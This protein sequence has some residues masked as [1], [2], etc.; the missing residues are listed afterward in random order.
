MVE[1]FLLLCNLAA[2]N[3]VRH[4]KRTAV[5]VMLISIT[6][7]LSF[8]ANAFFETSV[9][10][11][12]GTYVAGLTGHAVISEKAD[13]SFSLFGSEIPLVGQYQAIPVLSNYR[14]LKNLL[15]AKSDYLLWTPLV[16][17]ATRFQIGDMLSYQP[18]FGID[19]ESYIH[20]L[21]GIEIVW[22]DISELSSDGVFITNELAARVEAISGRPVERG[23]PV[24]FSMPTGSSFAIRKGRLAGVYSIQDGN[25]VTSN[26]VLT[27]PGIVRD[28]LE[29]PNGFV[30]T[31]SA[32]EN[33]E[34]DD[35]FDLDA[36][37]AVAEDVSEPDFDNGSSN[38][39]DNLQSTSGSVEYHFNEDLAA[40]N[41]ILLKART[42]PE[43]PF[44]LFMLDLL[45]DHNA[46]LDVL[47]WQAAAGASIQLL[48]IVQMIFVA[49]LAVVI[50][51]I[52]LI[53][54]NAL[55]LG[56]LERSS[57]IGTMRSIGAG[58]SFIRTLFFL[59]SFLVTCIATFIGVAIGSLGVLS[60]NSLDLT[61]SNQLLA[62]L[63][64]VGGIVE[65]N[66]TFSNMAKHLVGVILLGA[67]AWIY[68]VFI[69]SKTSPSAA[70]AKAAV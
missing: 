46:H 44:R 34:E 5:I 65:A 4:Y 26:I 48:L 60:I 22:G 63:I 56:V 3:S 58:F 8:I 37:F 45:G 16:S 13:Y 41:F 52:S 11:L 66:V 49:G 68:P 9:S 10:R 43:K 18:V 29:Y 31:Q 19:P 61:V 42:L 55:V 14:D 25:E 17:G 21:D 15:N 20:V 38:I 28:L 64:S 50:V 40:W 35:F 1:R 12:R 2:R 30:A 27:V 62:G 39:I 47:K 6:T 51:V 53:I 23:E 33:Q 70:I 7:A 54:I 67:I 24:I 57:E 69:A 32:L 59:E 36:L